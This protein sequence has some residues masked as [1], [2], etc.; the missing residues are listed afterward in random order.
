MSDLLQRVHDRML[1]LFEKVGTLAREL[2]EHRTEDRNGFAAVEAMVSRLEKKVDEGFEELRGADRKIRRKVSSV[3]DEVEAT[4]KHVA[5]ER[6]QWSKTARWI[7]RALVGLVVTAGT[8]AVGYY[9]GTSE[10]TSNAHE[11]AGK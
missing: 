6:K 8:G 9:F 2:A 4:G 3:V 7:V 1:D 5:L 10:H 11:R